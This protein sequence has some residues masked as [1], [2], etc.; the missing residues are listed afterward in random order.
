MKLKELLD[1]VFENGAINN[2]IDGTERYTMFPEHLKLYKDKLLECDEFKNV[3]LVIIDKPVVTYR[4]ILAEC[5]T[6]KLDNDIKFKEILYLYSL[7]LH[8]INK[9]IMLRGVFAIDK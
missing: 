9:N 4:N 5:Q 1:K 8:A 3:D 2:T 7:S 6:I